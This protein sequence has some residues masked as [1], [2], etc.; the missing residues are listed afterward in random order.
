M[1][2]GVWVGMAFTL[3][4]ALVVWMFFL[5]QKVLVQD[6]ERRADN[7]TY[8][9]GEIT[10]F[11]G[12]AHKYFDDGTL[13]ETVNYTD[14]LREGERTVWHINGNTALQE[15][16]QNGHLIIA[17]SFNFEGVPSGTFEGG[18]GRL[19]LYFNHTGTRNEELVYEGGQIAKRKI[20]DQN[21][22]LVA[23][24]PPTL[25]PNMANYTGPG[26][27]LPVPT[28]PIVPVPVTPPV[29]P[30]PPP[31]NAT[32]RVVTPTNTVPVVDPRIPDLNSKGRTNI[33][34][35]SVDARMAARNIR[36]RIDLIYLGK[37]Y[38]K[39]YTDFGWPDEDLGADWVYNGM[40][41]KNITSGGYLSRITFRYRNGT[42][43]KIIAEP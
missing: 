14:G 17:A 27:T 10:P 36:N 5:N 28:Q 9:K 2:I 33:W 16:Y 42:V 23:E 25:P 8:V 37:Q 38:T 26:S 35:Y 39:V 29:T 34:T 4:T 13:W 12:A 1:R 40:T 22:N 11:T 3:I 31:T 41:I 24:I 43:I 6:I 20:W 18:R 15:T 7:L 21:S 32:P 19:T 30:N